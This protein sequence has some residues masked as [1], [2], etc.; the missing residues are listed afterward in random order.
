[1]SYPNSPTAKNATREGEETADLF[2]PIGAGQHIQ[3]DVEDSLERIE[4]GGE[5]LVFVVVPVNT[6]HHED[7]HVV[8]CRIHVVSGQSQFH[9]DF[10]NLV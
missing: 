3:V 2:L 7:A 5:L 4:A 6:F 10:A 1:M 9:M 8:E